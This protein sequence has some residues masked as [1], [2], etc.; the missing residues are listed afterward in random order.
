[1]IRVRQHKAFTLVEVLVVIGVIAILI[2]FLLPMLNR[3]RSSAVSLQCSSNLRQIG[4]A[5]FIYAGESNGHLPQAC[6]EGAIV[7]T[8][9]PSRTIYTSDAQGRFS[10]AQ[11]GMMSRILK[12]N[13]R[14]W[15]C[16]GDRIAPPAGNLPIEEDD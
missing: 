5:A 14:I 10:M 12:G 7:V 13:T 2:G 9:A 3:S 11:A 15:Y 1:M 6:H 4:Q 8:A 16:A